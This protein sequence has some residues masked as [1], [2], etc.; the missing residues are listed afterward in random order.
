MSLTSRTALTVLAGL[1]TVPTT[2]VTHVSAS[3]A[4]PAFKAPGAYTA[5]HKEFYLSSDQFDFARPGLVFRINS[6]V[7]AGDR[8]PVVDVTMTDNLGAPVDRL[9]IQTPRLSVIVTST[10]GLRSPAMTTLLILKTSPGRA[11]SN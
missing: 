8:K 11:K 2:R 9:G 10:T 1:L 7:I 4:H 5:S 6:V 3:N